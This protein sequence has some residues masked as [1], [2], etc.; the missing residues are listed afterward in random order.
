MKRLIL[1]L[2]LMFVAVLGAAESDGWIPVEKQVGEAVAGPQVTVVHFWAP[3]CSNCQAELAKNGWK[4]FLAVNRDIRVIF[5]TVWNPE[6]GR[7]ELSKHGVGDQPNFQLLVHP[8]GS[9]K[10]EERM[11]RFLGQPIEWIPATWIFK[12]GQLRYALNYGEVRFP[13]LQQ[14]VRD[15]GDNWDHAKPK[16]VP[17]IVPEKP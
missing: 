6:D 16:D 3:W 9:R 10:K 11:N 1:A 4:D 2:N 7:A 8:N 15:A 17:K 14:L 5:V 12:D 13:L